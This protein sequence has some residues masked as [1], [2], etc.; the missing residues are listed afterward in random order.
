MIILKVIG[1]ILLIPVWVILGLTWVIVH[2][3]V[4]MFGVFHG[5][6]KIFFGLVAFL[7]LCFGMWQNAIAAVL[8][9]AATFLILLA[10]SFVESVIMLIMEGV[11]HVIMGYSEIYD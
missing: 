2:I 6:W 5:F 11:G 8:A 1:K 10:G 3:L 9:I 4:T 7:A